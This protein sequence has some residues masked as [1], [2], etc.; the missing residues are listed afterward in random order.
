MNCH[1]FGTIIPPF[2]LGKIILIFFGKEE[3]RLATN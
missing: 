1:R 2:T 3:L